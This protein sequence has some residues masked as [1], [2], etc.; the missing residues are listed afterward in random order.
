MNTTCLT[1]FATIVILHLEWPIHFSIMLSLGRTG[2]IYKMQPSKFPQR[3]PRLC[4]NE[5][6]EENNLTVSVFWKSAN[7]RLTRYLRPLKNAQ[8]FSLNLG[9]RVEGV[10]T[11]TFAISGIKYAIITFVWASGRVTCPLPHP[12]PNSTMSL[13]AGGPQ[14]IVLNILRLI[15]L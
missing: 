8:P 10:T 7:C 15:L 4:W 1:R 2:C 6:P 5:Y 11:G 14:S 13:F 9:V 3:K 12:H